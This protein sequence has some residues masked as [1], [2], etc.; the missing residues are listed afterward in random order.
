M[1]AIISNVSIISFLLTDHVL[2]VYDTSLQYSRR[3][4]AEYCKILHVAIS[5][6]AN[7]ANVLHYSEYLRG[8]FPDLIVPHVLHEL[9]ILV[10][11]PISGPWGLL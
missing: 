8:T 4:T 2:P 6:C 7:T 1:C 5:G 3:N 10:D 11:S 9:H